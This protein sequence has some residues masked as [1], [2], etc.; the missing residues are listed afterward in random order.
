MKAPG[1]GYFKSELVLASVI[2]DDGEIHQNTSWETYLW[3]GPHR[4][5][6]LVGTPGGL[7]IAFLAMNSLPKPRGQMPRGQM[8]AGRG[9]HSVAVPI[10]DFP[11]RPIASH[12]PESI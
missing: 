5:L 6:H 10:L 8:D 2:E 9:R 12:K 4:G 3:G 7:G 11:T 1:G